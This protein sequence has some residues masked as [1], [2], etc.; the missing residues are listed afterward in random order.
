MKTYKHTL[1]QLS[2]ILLSLTLFGC[3]PFTGV[4]LDP[5]PRPHTVDVQLIHPTE[6]PTRPF[7]E[8][9]L[10]TYEVGAPDAAIKI[11][12]ML[13]R[14]KLLGADALLLRSRS[15]SPTVEDP[16]WGTASAIVY[17]P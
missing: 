10:F 3:A 17:T 2:G 15:N 16:Q 11:A 9:A 6:Y 1:S 13:K 8:I 14:C 12:A 7:K 4:I 5:T